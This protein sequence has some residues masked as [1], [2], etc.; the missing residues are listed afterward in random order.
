MD[1]R[2]LVSLIEQQVASS[3]GHWG[4]GWGISG[5]GL[6]TPIQRTSL[7]DQRANALIYYE[8]QPFG[9]ELEGESQVVSSDVFDTVEGMLPALLKIFTASD[10]VVE[11]EP[12]GPEDEA[13]ARQ[14]TEV[15]NYV[16]MRQNNG[17]LNL[18]E[19]FKDAL[20]QN[21]GIVKYWWD[22]KQT[23]AKETYR[24]LSEK[25]MDELLE[26]EGGSTVELLEHE[27]VED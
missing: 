25:Q 17:F 12:N 24:G 20:I 8:R 18:Y 3:I 4:A 19:W 11:F 1:E 6:G 27:E 22:E 2:E 13:Q 10:D 21:N 15:V 16:M 14:Q 26:G 23:K 7:A 9:N 5:T